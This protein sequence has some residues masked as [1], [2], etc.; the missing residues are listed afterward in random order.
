MDA[1]GRAQVNHTKG[2]DRAITQVATANH[3]KEETIAKLLLLGSGESGKSTFFRQ[4]T[5]SF[6]KGFT[7]EVRITHRVAIH[8]G[9]FDAL[10]LLLKDNAI[11]EV[12]E[13]QFRLT[14]GAKAAEIAKTFT[15]QERLTKKHAAVIKALWADPAFKLTFEKRRSVLISESA[16]YFFERIEKICAD[17]YIPDDDDLIHMRVRTTGIIREEFMV[18]NLRFALHD[19]GGQ[20]N[21][22]R[23][24]IQ[25]FDG[26]TAVIF[27]T[28]ISEY[29]Q[30]CWEDEG[31]NRMI[32]S[33]NVFEQTFTMHFQATPIILFL[34]KRD[35]FDKKFVKVPLENFFPDWNGG[36]KEEAYD[37]FK[38]K[39]LDRLSRKR[40]V[41]SHVTN[42]T[43]TENCVRVFHAVRHIIVKIQLGNS[44]FM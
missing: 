40:D 38:D 1:S 26:V 28:A 39:F 4:M 8:Q 23:K 25:M 34:N 10:D 5:K 6:G 15:K 36:T 32:E 7:D 44:G 12:K 29:D 24:W 14:E 41:F 43:D 31:T 35:L 18:E 30:V 19:V 21:E 17:D 20:R 3:I 11:L 42:A 13:E 16:A 37:F 33:L 9:V 2:L 22:R 27:I